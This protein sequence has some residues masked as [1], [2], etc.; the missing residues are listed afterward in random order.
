MKTTY[1][2]N[3]TALLVVITLLSLIL[4]NVLFLYN[5]KKLRIRIIAK[6]L[7]SLRLF[8]ACYLIAKISRHLIM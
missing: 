1:Y 7:K 3:I 8:V 4:D 5:E 6:N 2:I